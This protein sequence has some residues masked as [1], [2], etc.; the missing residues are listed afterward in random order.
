MENKRKIGMFYLGLVCLVILTI[1]V[2]NRAIIYSGAIQAL[3]FG[4]F[5]F[6]SIL[7]VLPICAGLLYMFYINKS[8]IAKVFVIASILLIVFSIFTSFIIARTRFSVAQYIIFPLI[9]IAAGWLIVKSLKSDK[10]K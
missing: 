9:Y 5:S 2:T 8:I 7:I 3:R 6:Y 1:Y 10:E 4:R